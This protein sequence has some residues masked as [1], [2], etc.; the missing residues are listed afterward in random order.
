MET[1]GLSLRRDRCTRR[2]GFTLIELLVV[3]AIIAL[4]ISILLPSLSKARQQ[5]KQIVCVSN[6]RQIGIA[7][8]RYFLDCNEWFP[9]AKSNRGYMHGFYYGGHPGRQ[10]S[11]DQWWGYVDPLA[12]DTPAGRPFNNYIYPDLPDYDVQPTDPQ[13]ELVRN[14]PLYR[15]PSD[16][17]GMWNTETGDETTSNQILYWETGSSY[18]CNYH[19]VVNWAMGK[20]PSEDPPRWQHRTN[21]FLRVQLAKW[22]STFIILYEDPFDSAQWNRIP[23]RGWHGQMNRHSLLFLDSHAA[24]MLTD[25]AK[26]ARGLGWKSCSGKGPTDPK[27]WW[28]M[29]DWQDPDAQYKNIPPLPGY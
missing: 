11:S 1:Q 27:A 12:R 25:T 7:M 5:G 6:L 9:W 17:G 15:C 18:D 3:V 10:Y 2:L 22:A 28:N 14:L 16:T 21:A 19:F 29:W 13:F 20:F 26:G 4:L 24:N 8:S 23:R